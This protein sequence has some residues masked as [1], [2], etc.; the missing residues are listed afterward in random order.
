MPTCFRRKPASLRATVRLMSLA[1]LLFAACPRHV[2]AQGTAYV[3]GYVL[4]S[5]TDTLR[6]QLQSQK[7]TATPQTVRFRPSPS[8]EARRVSVH[9]AAGYGLDGFVFERHAVRVDE[10][11]LVSGK[12][13]PGPDVA[14]RDTLFLQKMVDGPL[15]LY[16]YQDDRPHFYLQQKGTS[17]EE[18][19]Y[20]VRRGQSRGEVYEVKVRRYRAQLAAA[21]TDACRDLDTG[22]LRYN[23]ASL[24]RFV[25]ACNGQAGTDYSTEFRRQRRLAFGHAVELRSGWT[26]A[27]YDD[28]FQH[29]MEM[30]G[31]SAGGG[32][33]LT[34]SSIQPDS[35]WLALV[36]VGVDWF[37]GDDA[38]SK[39]VSGDVVCD[40]E[41][42]GFRNVASR[43]GDVEWLYST[44][45]VGG[46]FQVTEYR[47]HPFLE[48]AFMLRVPLSFEM[49][50]RTDNVTTYRVVDGQ[51]MVDRVFNAN[52]ERFAFSDGG[53]QPGLR[54][55]GGFSW[56]DFSLRG[57]YVFGFSRSGGTGIAPPTRSLNLALVYRL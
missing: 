47:L 34:L 53:V 18:L 40:P 23:T 37:R 31:Q 3:D 30:T 10:R 4:A 38:V 20:H 24:S 55:G 32:Y 36:N 41:C 51:E 21:Q 16:Y 22:D 27:A 48:S 44:V 52:A 25:Q 2:P 45:Q 5:P 56:Q 11:P 14:R 8:A 35:R 1:L 7:W 19:I 46:R 39:Q 29:G 13:S 6:G 26:T 28:L 15:S 57:D 17:P 33:V 49:N 42:N 12:P 50:A 9:D 43:S 54:I